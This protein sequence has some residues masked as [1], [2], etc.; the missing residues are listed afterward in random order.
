M[1]FGEKIALYFAWLEFMM[2][3][4]LVP[5]I[6]GFIVFIIMFAANDYFDQS[7][8][9]SISEIALLVFTIVLLIMGTFMDNLW[10]RK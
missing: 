1:Y 5:A 10:S 2:W 7:I 4:L 8:E 6:I 3:W 9:M